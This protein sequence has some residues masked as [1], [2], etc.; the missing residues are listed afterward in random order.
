MGLE[1]KNKALKEFAHI[2]LVIDSILCLMLKCKGQCLEVECFMLLMVKFDNAFVK[3]F[4]PII[5]T[6]GFS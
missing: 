3:N 6:A 2:L 5:L 4:S 1:G